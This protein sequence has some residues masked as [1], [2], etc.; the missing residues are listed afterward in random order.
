MSETHV[1]NEYFNHDT[2][3]LLT[4]EGEQHRRQRKI[5]SPA[6]SAANIRAVTPIFWDKAREVGLVSSPIGDAYVLTSRS[7]QLRDTWLR[8]VDD[9]EEEEIHTSSASFQK[10]TPAATQDGTRIDALAWLGRATL[11]I[12]G[13][14][15]FGYAFN[16]LTDEANELA[17][18][19]AAVFSTAR[20]FRVM[21]IL[22][23]WFPI[24]RGFVSWYFYLFASWLL[25]R[26]IAF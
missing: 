26:T 21:T 22:Q 10:E 11:D 8:I 25:C 14:A 5:I 2:K 9:S 4:T 19:F 12:I 7:L 3:G 17:L 16:S 1:N 6:F 13:L 20:K 18:A 24:L 15:G 23:A